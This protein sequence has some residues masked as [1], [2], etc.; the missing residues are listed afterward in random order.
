MVLFFRNKKLTHISENEN[1]YNRQA[2]PK[3]ILKK[4][5]KYRPYGKK[6]YLC[7]APWTSL[8]LSMSG[9]ALVCCFNRRYILG[10]FPEQNLHAI[11]FNSKREKLQ[12]YV[13]KNNLSSGCQICKEHLYANRHT[14]IQIKDYDI[15]AEKTKNAYPLQI[16]FE[17]SNEC[18]LDCSMCFGEFSSYI[19]KNREKQ[20]V[21]T[22]PYN[23]DLLN[24]LDEFLP[25]VEQCI[26]VGGEP[27]LIEKYYTI[28]NKLKK[29]N[30]KARIIIVSNATVLNENIKSVIEKGQFYF[31][32]SIDSFRKETYEFIRKNASFEKTMANFYY[33]IDYSKKHNR[34]ISVNICPLLKNWEEIPEIIE[35]LNM[36]NVNLYINN[37]NTPFDQS[38]RYLN[39]DK[40]EEIIKNFESV[41][42]K[43]TSSV[44]KK[45]IV[46]FKDFINQLKEW[47]LTSVNRNNTSDKINT[48]HE[49][50]TFFNSI[51]QK[52]YISDESDNDFIAQKINSYCSRL[53]EIAKQI[54]INE[55]FITGL[56]NLCKL[57]DHMLLAEFEINSNDILTQR[58]IQFATNK[59]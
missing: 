19:R 31:A 15:Y 11:W 39:P 30:P 48:V 34:W 21:I 14:L 2:I 1:K 23:D 46:L 33:F 56:I 50:I 55:T 13:K 18:N 57:P 20:L 6:P 3:N 43:N 58:I 49:A 17:L 59:I 52:A 42:F 44:S 26:F 32:L 22:S 9:H 35:K 12:D 25:H 45:N 16:E 41:K 8:R 28:W 54:N 24:Q 53:N 29:I 51:I 36:L 37:V 38:L 40:L 5:N 7:Y 4:Y 47:K 10:K 27:F